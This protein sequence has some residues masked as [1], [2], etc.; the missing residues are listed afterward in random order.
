MFDILFPGNGLIRSPFMSYQTL[1]RTEFILNEEGVGGRGRE[2]GILKLLSVSLCSCFSRSLFEVSS[3]A[4]DA[5][6]SE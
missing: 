2:T 5:E 3:K 1:K 4:E 6:S